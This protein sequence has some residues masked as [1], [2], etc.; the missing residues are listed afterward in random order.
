M[1]NLLVAYLKTEVEFTVQI[2][3]YVV[4]VHGNKFRFA[5]DN[6]AVI[7]RFGIFCNQ[8]D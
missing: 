4:D 3:T 8:T 1:Q 5:F 6:P 2:I 7:R